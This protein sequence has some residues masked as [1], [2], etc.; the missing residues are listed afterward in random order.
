MLGTQGEHLNFGNT[1]E[2][3]PPMASHPVLDEDTGSD[4]DTRG[5]VPPSVQSLE[6][7][8]MML[9]RCMWM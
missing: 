9:F 4:A 8:K 1:A 5:S 3:A 2:A 7:H 6:T